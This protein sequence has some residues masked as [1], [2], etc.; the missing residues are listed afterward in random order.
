MIDSPVHRL[1]H[2]FS[3]LPASLRVM[4]TAVLLMLGMGYLF[5]IVYLFHNY[6]G[7][8]GNSASLSYDDVVIAYSGTGK[9]SRLEAALRGSMSVMLPFEERDVLLGWVKDGADRAR[10]EPEVRPILDRRCMACHDGSNPNLVNLN[11]FDNMLKVTEQDTGAGFF[12]LVRVSHIHMFGLTFVFFLMGT[13]FSHAYVRPVWFKCTVMALPFISLAL[14]ISS[15]YFTKLFH[16]F[17]GVVIVSGAVMGLSFAYMWFVSM[18]QLWF[19]K[20]PAA[21]AQRSESRTPDVG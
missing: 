11:G 19:A 15:W 6:S 20:L 13:I 17:A 7:K 21:I 1:Y 9:G 18:Y 2:H 4:Y 14:D 10:F 3:E 5:A 12:T 8:D 16:P